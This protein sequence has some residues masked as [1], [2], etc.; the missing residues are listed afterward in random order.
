MV[1]LPSGR[2]LGHVRFINAENVKVTCTLHRNCGLPLRLHGVRD[3]VDESIDCFF[4]FGAALR[5]SED[6]QT[7]HMAEACPEILRRTSICN[8]DSYMK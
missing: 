2:K 1:E 8:I 4:K 5:D 6:A 7:R 3:Y